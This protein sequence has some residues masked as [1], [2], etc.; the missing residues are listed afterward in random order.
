MFLHLHNMARNSNNSDYQVVRDCDYKGRHYSVRDNGSVYRHPNGPINSKWDG[1][2]TFGKQDTHNGYMFIGSERVHRIVATAFLGEPQFPDMVVDHIDTNRANNR[3][4][5]LRWLTRLENVLSNEITRKRII[6]LC[7]SIEAFLADPS[8]IRSKAIS[9]DLS[10]MRTVTKEEAYACKVNMEKWVEKKD[11]IEI[12]RVS[13][14]E[15]EVKPMS[16]WIFLANRDSSK[17]EFIEYKTWECR[18]VGH[19]ESCIYLKAPLKTV[20]PVEVMD[21]YYNSLLFDDVFIE[22]RYYSLFVSDRRKTDINEM[23]VLADRKGQMMGWYVFRIWLEDNVLYHQK[24]AAFGKAQKSKALEIY[25]GK[26]L[27]SWIGEY[28][29]S[30]YRKNV[31]GVKRISESIHPLPDSLRK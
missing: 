13:K 20:S 4:D 26:Q 3:P 1:V 24:I 6:Y 17:D 10:W 7:G 11:T 8:I 9:S 31:K 21:V 30:Y 25:N 15:T 27:D 12:S 29:Y 18:T 2:W 19:T 16:K 14:P 28:S 22:S 5:N 23:Y